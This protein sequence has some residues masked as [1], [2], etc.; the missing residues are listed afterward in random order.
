M[1][2]SDSGAIPGTYHLYN[3][4]AHAA[5]GSI[6]TCFPFGDAR[7]GRADAGMASTVAYAV[8]DPH[9]RMMDLGETLKLPAKY[10]AQRARIEQVL[11]PLRMPS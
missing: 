8:P 7:P 11:P 2:T 9:K 3:G 4:D 6:M 10:E 5:P 1:S